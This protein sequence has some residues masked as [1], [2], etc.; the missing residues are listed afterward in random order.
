MKPSDSHSV[1]EELSA[2]IDGELEPVATDRLLR[3]LVADPKARETLRRQQQ[4]T[5]DSRR[6]IR[7]LTPPPS[8]LLLER[9]QA[10]TESAPATDVRM[11]PRKP[12]VSWTAIPYAAAAALLLA[13]GLWAGRYSQ[14]SQ[15]VA[16]RFTPDSAA[17]DVLPAIAI[18]QAE[19]IHG[20]CSR[21][22]EG[23]HTAG[24]PA[25]LE[26]LA[27]S[28]QRD[29]HGDHPY[30]N[31]TAIGYRY[32]GAGPCG[33][34]LR[35]TVH[36]L[37][38]STRP[39]SVKAISVFAQPWRGQF[40]LDEGRVYTVSVATSPFPMLA[41]RTNEVVYYLLADDAK[42]LAQ[43]AALMRGKPTTEPQPTQPK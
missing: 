31:F 29:L 4:L 30:P 26:P 15:R 40:A 5:V 17:A 27:L 42:T 33:V 37:Y 22:A 6:A 38:R 13:F 28:V 34:P 20:F 32:R 35:D 36:L 1:R 7:A 25:Q 10:L 16:Q 11:R 41:W 23:L 9:L 18:S 14:R 24:Y 21:L 19:E 12:R 3:H 43:A 8:A 39:G 2:F